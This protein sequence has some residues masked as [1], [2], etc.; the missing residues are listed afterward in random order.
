[1][2]KLPAARPEPG[3]RKRPDCGLERD[4]GAVRGGGGDVDHRAALAARLDALH[5]PQLGQP[6][7]VIVQADGV[8]VAAGDF[9]LLLLRPDR[10][11]RRSALSVPSITSCRLS[12]NSWPTPSLLRTAAT[13]SPKSPP[14]SKLPGRRLSPE[15]RRCRRRTVNGSNRTTLPTPLRWSGHTYF[16]RLKSRFIHFV[17]IADT[18]WPPFFENV[19]W[20]VLAA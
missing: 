7:G 12:R 19:S 18:R 20:A 6:A 1:M 17:M 11:G 2:S 3:R 15:S 5:L 14:I 9:L 16:G 8:V 13:A 4:F 10:P